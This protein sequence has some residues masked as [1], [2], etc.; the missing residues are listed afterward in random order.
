MFFNPTLQ[1]ELH[2]DSSWKGYDASLLQRQSDNK[3]H[4]VHFFSAK[5]TETQASYRSFELETL[6]IFKTIMKFRMN[7]LGLYFTIVT[8]CSTIKQQLSKRDIRLKINSWCLLFQEF[9]Y[10]LEHQKGDR[11]CHVDSLSRNPVMV[12]ENNLALKFLL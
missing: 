5:T 1:T 12:I 8:D 3:F 10:K 7:L 2:T 11:M 9:N 4:P 6:A